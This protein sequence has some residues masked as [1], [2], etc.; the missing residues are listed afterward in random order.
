MIIVWFSSTSLLL[1]PPVHLNDWSWMLSLVLPKLSNNKSPPKWW[2]NKTSESYKKE[3]LE[4]NIKHNY[5][6]WTTWNKS[7]W[8]LL[9]KPATVLMLS[10][11]CRLSQETRMVLRHQASQTEA[12]GLQRICAG[13][14]TPK[15]LRTRH[16]T[17][18]FYIKTQ[19]TR[20]QSQCPQYM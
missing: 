7:Y 5:W 11:T 13:H 16:I 14:L 1:N 18:Y 10:G 6:P 20:C 8:L 12:S 19:P 9:T 17:W 2:P 15:E 4:E 3:G